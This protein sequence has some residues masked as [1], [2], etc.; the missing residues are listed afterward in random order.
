MQNCLILIYIFLKLFH[1][2]L[3]CG[4]AKYKINILRFSTEYMSHVVSTRLHRKSCVEKCIL[5]III[6][7]IQEKR[8]HLF[9]AG[10]V[11]SLD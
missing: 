9:L 2:H 8:T 4:S 6:I 7:P 10:W 5:N 1:L 3:F 11:L